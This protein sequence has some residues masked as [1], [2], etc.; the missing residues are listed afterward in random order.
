[1]NKQIK[2]IACVAVSAITILGAAAF[3]AGCSDY[4]GAD[5]LPGYV[6]SANKAESNGGFAVKKDNYVYFI[7]GIE[8]YDAV[9]DYN[10]PVKGGI[11]RISETNL[12][13]HNYAA[14]DRV[15]PK[16]VYSGNYDAGIFIYGDYVYYTT[17]STE[18]D[19][20]GA[21][22][23]TVLEFTSTKLDGTQTRKNPYL[24]LDDNS[25]KYRFVEEGGTVYILYEETADSVT[26]LHS[27]NTA[28]GTD[29][30][31]AYNT[32]EI[33]YD[34]TDKTNSRVFYTMNV[35]NY[36][37]DSN[38]AYSYNQI[39]TVTASATEDKFK[40]LDKSTILGWDEENDKYV[41]C[42]DLVYDGIGRSDSKTP[43]NYDFQGQIDWSG[44]TYN[45]Q[46]YQN[47]TVFY[48]RTSRNNSDPYLFS[49][50]DEAYKAS[51]YSPVTANPTPGSNAYI[52]SYGK[53]SDIKADIYT[54]LFDG[55]DN[56]E[57]VLI[58]ENNGLTINYTTT[59]NGA[60]KLQKRTS[61]NEQTSKYFSIVGGG[62]SAATILYVDYTNKYVYY[63]FGSSTINRI[64]YDGHMSKYIVNVLPDADSDYDAVEILDLQTSASWYAPEF[65]DGQIL[66]A[67]ATSQMSSYN[68]I[69]A[70]DL[71][72]LSNSD[73]KKLT[74]QYE[75]IETLIV[76]T[77][78]DTEK[79][80]SET[81]AN[82]Q[83]A[84]RYAY[85]TGEDKSVFL[86]GLAE[87]LNAELEEDDNLIYS[88]ETLKAYDDFLTPTADNL[89]KDYRESKKV[90]GETVYA[91]RHE[92]YYSVLG[93]MKDSDS[94]SYLTGLR[95][96]FLV[97]E[98]V[99]ETTWWEGLSTAAKVW[100]IIGIVAGCL[101]VIAAVTVGVILIVRYNKK[102]S[103]GTRR[104]RIKVDLTD[105][106]NID[107]YGTGETR[108]TENSENE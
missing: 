7:N 85:Y 40:D 96:S 61:N 11:Y 34:K 49:F 89:W 91:N 107:V 97:N 17:P 64:K 73:I 92:Y 104:R 66:F 62:S 77:Y 99:E 63:T 21:I 48:T 79:Y 43:F 52:L 44:Y 98:T 10:T 72:G 78:S 70:C 100:I 19:A 36:V 83:N 12:K 18:K 20:N 30:V 25:A 4:F 80:P 51:G 58:P 15:V 53:E 56:L 39:Y 69:M 60:L 90:N 93:V 94:E 84:L 74:E 38:T 103:T 26:S 65:I 2:K 68:T 106:K 5:A 29:T 31:L 37:G 105:D 82:V 22:Q 32:T 54:Y 42:G 88:A 50:K 27:Y 86:S 67:S 75:G 45:L 23:N 101:V 14:V 55:N 16:I 35:M 46:N 108:N 71:S 87:R 102:K 47:G 28:N 81:Y 6:S 59:E 1:M 13:E 41:N 76:D 8:G 24:R 9:N 95:N 33:I 3:S 57:A